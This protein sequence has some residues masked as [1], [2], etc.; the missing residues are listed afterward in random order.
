V[1]DWREETVRITTRRFFLKTPAFMDAVGKF[2]SRVAHAWWDSRPTSY[3]KAHRPVGASS[4]FKGIPSDAFTYKTYD[5]EIVIEFSYEQPIE[6]DRVP[7]FPGQR[8]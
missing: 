6:N 7:G 4:P 1:S 5:N 8:S 2:E 3:Q